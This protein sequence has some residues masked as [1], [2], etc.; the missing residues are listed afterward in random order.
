MKRRISNATLL[1]MF[2]VA[3]VGSGALAPGQDPAAEGQWGPVLN[4]PVKAIHM[5][6]LKNGKVLAFQGGTPTACILFDPVTGNV[7]S[8]N[9]PENPLHKLL[10]SGHAALSDGKILFT[11]GVP[12]VPTTTLY[13]PDVDPPGAASWI[14]Q[15][16]GSGDPVFTDRFYP[17]CTT[18]GD[19]TVLT[20]AGD[21]IAAPVA[22]TPAIFD[23][24]Q[25]TGQDLQ[26]TPSSSNGAP[27]W[28]PT[29]RSG[30]LWQ[31]SGMT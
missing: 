24:T 29:P 7:T 30:V 31:S 4:W 14:P 16:P 25:P 2:L 26:W 13:D 5:F 11:G 19:G 27:L 22:D 23:A 1:G 15:D 10:S 20:M 6:V 17:T 12:P 28:L 3:T 18:L 8:F 21:G 9:G